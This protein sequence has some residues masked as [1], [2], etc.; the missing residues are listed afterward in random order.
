MKKYALLMAVLTIGC[1]NPAQNTTKSAINQKQATLADFDVCADVYNEARL[2]DL[3]FENTKQ[4]LKYG[5]IFYIGKDG[6]VNAYKISS[7]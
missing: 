2:E 7:F 6:A 4:T 5:Y 1:V 3:Y